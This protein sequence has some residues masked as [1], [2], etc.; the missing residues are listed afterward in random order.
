MYNSWSYN[1]FI[2][3]LLLFKGDK[4]SSE[5]VIPEKS[6]AADVAAEDISEK[7]QETSEKSNEKNVCFVSSPIF[8]LL[9]F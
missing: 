9:F 7:K 4:S 6:E 1:L 8:F 5:T 2:C 3:V